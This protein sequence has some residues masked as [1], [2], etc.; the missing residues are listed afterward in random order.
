MDDRQVIEKQEPARGRSDTIS[1]K[2]LD[3]RRSSDENK[4]DD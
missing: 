4:R 3:R 1:D 2:G